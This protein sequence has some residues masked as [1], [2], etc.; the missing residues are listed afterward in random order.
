[1]N[2]TTGV[3]MA[4]YN[5]ARYIEEQM[6]SIIGQTLAPDIIVVVDDSS[7][8]GTPHILKEY[9]DRCKNIE[10]YENS[11]NMGCIRTFGKGISL[12]EA[13][14]IALSDQDNIWHPKKLEKCL[15]SLQQNKGCGLCYHNADL[16]YEDGSPLEASLWE[17]SDLHY[18]LTQAEAQKILLGTR[19]PVLGFTIV[20]ESELKEYIIQNPGDAFCSHDWWIGAVA[21][22]LYDPVY[23]ESGLTRFR[24]HRDQESGA[25]DCLLEN[26]KYQIEKRIMDWERIKRNVGRIHHNLFHSKEVKAKRIRDSRRREMEFVDAFETFLAIM[27][28][29]NKADNRI[30]RSAIV[31]T[32][33]DKKKE[34]GRCSS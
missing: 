28:Q 32:L 18:P 20:F 9:G 24:L 8:D 11:E 29:R 10:V 5:G 12:C 25:M 16:M 34:F 13:D 26:T 1:M 6:D 17:L 23:I 21:F 2:I 30:D 22:F 31:N 27:E 4:T 7:T 14:Y 33:L 3:V 15:Q 19:V